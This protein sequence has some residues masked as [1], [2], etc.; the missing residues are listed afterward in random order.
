MRSTRVP[1]RRS[2]PSRDSASR[3]ALG[4]VGVLAGQEL[5]RALEEGHLRAEA[6]EG[7]RELAADR[8]AADHGQPPR[9]LGQRED[10]LVREVAG[11]G[12]PGDGRLGRAGA[13]RDHR[14]LEAERPSRDVDGCPVR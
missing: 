6:R 10:R 14:V 5:A 2:T 8:A 13:R 9:Q 3:D 11:L 12:Q 7:L 4:G 1:S